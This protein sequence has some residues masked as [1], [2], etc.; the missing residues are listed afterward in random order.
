MQLMECRKSQQGFIAQEFVN[1]TLLMK[2]SII[3]ISFKQVGK[4]VKTSNAQ[5]SIESLG[6]FNNE[7]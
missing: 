5:S 3:I 4:Y 6:I 7:I 1:Q 2:A